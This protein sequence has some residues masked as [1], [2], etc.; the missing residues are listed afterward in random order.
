MKLA[1]GCDEAGL[2]LKNV[3]V[4]FLQEQT[5]VPVEI[6]D[7]GV[8]SP[9]PV[10]YPDIAVAVAEAVSNHQADRAILICGTGIGMSITANKVPGVRAAQAHDVYSAERAR[11]SNDAQVLTM[12]AGDRAG[13]AKKIV[14]AWLPSEFAGGLDARCRRWRK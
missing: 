12:G 11:K 8:N 10:D 14:E 7:F 6:T 9:D 2:E 5:S 4:K 13:L 1:I 3:L